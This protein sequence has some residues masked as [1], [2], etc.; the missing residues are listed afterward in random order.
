LDVTHHFRRIEIFNLRFGTLDDHLERYIG[1][2][3]A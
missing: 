3:D 1:L 2:L